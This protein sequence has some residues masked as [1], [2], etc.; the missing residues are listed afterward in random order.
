MQ[1]GAW[2]LNHAVTYE[3]WYKMLFSG[4]TEACAWRILPVDQHVTPLV[5]G[6]LLVSAYALQP[7]FERRVLLKRLG[8]IGREK[9]FKIVEREP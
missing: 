6:E 4:V 2:S 5:L 9:G 1:L 3:E 8:G 7:L